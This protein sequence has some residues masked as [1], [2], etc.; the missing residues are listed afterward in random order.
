MV[1]ISGGTAAV[2]DQGIFGGKAGSVTV[3]RW[4]SCTSTWD[5]EQTIDEPLSGP[6]DGT[7]DMF[8]SSL[9]LSGDT[10]VIGANYKDMGSGTSGDVWVYTRSGTTW[11]KSQELTAPTGAGLYWGYAIS[12]YGSSMAIGSSQGKDPSSSVIRTGA[13]AIYEQ[14]PTGKY[15]EKTLFTSANA[16]SYDYF[17]YSIALDDGSLVTGAPSNYIWPNSAPR[18]GKAW[19][20]TGSAATWTESAMLTASDGANDDWFGRAVAKS[21]NTVVVGAPKQD[22]A[23]ADAGAA[24]VFTYA[25]GAFRQTAKLTAPDAT[26]GA[27]FGFTVATVSST[28]ILVGAPDAGPGKIYSFSYDGTSWIQDASYWKCNGH[29]GYALAVSGNLAITAIPGGAVFDLAE[30]NA[31]CVP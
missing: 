20:F 10:L 25:N 17:G 9:S 2:G 29:S 30:A 24:Y 16:V 6:D 18:P 11:S 26:D 12:Q 23:G 4:N 21:G 1:G 22:G 19:I 14:G 5:L 8:G 7:K 27:H 3:S 31:A 13:V 15:T 28:R